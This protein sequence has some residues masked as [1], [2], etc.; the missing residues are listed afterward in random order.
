MTGDMLANALPPRSAIVAPLTS[1]VPFWASSIGPIT[2]W[3]QRSSPVT[4]M[5]KAAFR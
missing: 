3:T 5:S 2:C 1:T 4:P